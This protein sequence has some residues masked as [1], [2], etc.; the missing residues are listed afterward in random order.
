[1]IPDSFPVVP[2][3]TMLTDGAL[4]LCSGVT[5]DTSQPHLPKAEEKAQQDTSQYHITCSSQGCAYSGRD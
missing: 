2:Q 5:A 1:M 4:S 3:V